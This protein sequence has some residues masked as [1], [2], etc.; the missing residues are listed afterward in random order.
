MKTCIARTCPASGR[1]VEEVF[2]AVEERV[3]PRV[4]EI[5]QELERGETVWPV[6]DYCMSSRTAAVIR[7]T[8]S[9]LTEAP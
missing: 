5:V 7:E 3:A 4:A 9:L 1:T 8:V 2:A 6:I